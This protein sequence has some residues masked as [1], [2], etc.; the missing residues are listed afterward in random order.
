MEGFKI[1]GNEEHPDSKLSVLCRGLDKQIE[2]VSPNM[3]LSKSLAAIDQ[4]PVELL[5]KIFTYCITPYAVRA[6]FNGKRI[7][8]WISFT[9]VC[10]LWRNVALNTPS[11]WTK[12]DFRRPTLASEMLSRSKQAPLTIKFFPYLSSRREWEALGRA[13]AH[14]AHISTLKLPHPIATEIPEDAVSHLTYPAPLLNKLSFCCS[15]MHRGSGIISIPDQFLGRHYPKLTHLTFL[16]CHVPWNSQF[17]YT[18]DSL[19]CFKILWGRTAN[20][21]TP[22]R[23]QLWAILERMPRLRKLK[24]LDA[25]PSRVSEPPHSDSIINL[26]NLRFLGLSS[27]VA[28]CADFLLRISAPHLMTVDF[29]SCEFGA[30]NREAMGEELHLLKLAIKSIPMP[31]ENDDL[32]LDIEGIAYEGIAYE[33]R[34]LTLQFGP[35]PS[36]SVPMD[37]CTL[38]DH[39]PLRP[40]L[41]EAKW[42]R[43]TSYTGD[44]VISAF[45][46]SVNLCNLTSLSA[47]LCQAAL[48]ASTCS[49][50][51]ASLERLETVQL[52][53]GTLSNFLSILGSTIP[54]EPHTPSFPALQHIH[55]HGSFHPNNAILDTLIEACERRKTSRLPIPTVHLLNYKL[56]DAQRKLLD[57]HL[58]GHWQEESLQMNFTVQVN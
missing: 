58:H 35:L 50:L 11:L 42:S 18:L 36:T 4:L 3:E 10:Q 12:P 17:L 6:N 7:E 16:S 20:Y 8:G 39:G 22:T 19:T 28:D 13:F 31:A 40:L 54:T 56:E 43:Q 44:E 51:F 37:C 46:S 2:R 48:S 57:Q 15:V 25:V 41:F 49:K 27:I 32:Y 21:E 52:G 55:M 14:I 34:G 45:L 33:G 47:Y 5:S 30:Q 26:P 9:H 38:G 23:R 1:K 53:G 29:D 24:L